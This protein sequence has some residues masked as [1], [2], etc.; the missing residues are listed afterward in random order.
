MRKKLILASGRGDYGNKN[1]K[2][3]YGVAY[4]GVWESLRFTGV[5]SQAVSILLVCLAGIWLQSP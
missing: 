3:A 1:A 2:G 5:W 4:Y